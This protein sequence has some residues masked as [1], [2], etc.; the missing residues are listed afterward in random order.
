VGIQYPIKSEKQTE[1][2][3]EYMMSD[4]THPEIIQL[5][6]DFTRDLGDNIDVEDYFPV[7]VQVLREIELDLTHGH[8]ENSSAYRMLLND[9]GG[10][11]QERLNGGK[12]TENI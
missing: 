7:L 1:P 3:K 6:Q 10:E 4:S 12:W 9:L 5:I 2:K 8:E 11:I